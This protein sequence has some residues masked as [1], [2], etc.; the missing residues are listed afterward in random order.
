MDRRVARNRSASSRRGRSTARKAGRV[1]VDFALIA[2]E[3]ISDREWPLCERTLAG[4][5]LDPDPYRRP[6]ARDPKLPAEQGRPPR[7]VASRRFHLLRADADVDSESS[8]HTH[9][10]SGHALGHGAM[11]VAFLWR[12]AVDHLYGD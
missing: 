3:P 9:A 4:R 5:A 12:H 11:F 10:R 7:R 2:A 6:D 8:L 1:C